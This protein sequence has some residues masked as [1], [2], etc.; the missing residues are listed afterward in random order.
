MSRWFSV[1]GA[2]VSAT[3]LTASGRPAD[4][5]M[6]PGTGTIAGKVTLTLARSAPLPTSAY[7]RRDVA[8]KA[9]QAVPPMRS[10]VVYLSGA[11]P[12]APPAPMVARIVQRGEQ[13]HPPVTVI[14]AGSTVEFPNEDP[15]FHNVFSL[16]R[17]ASFDLGRYRSGES[18]SRRFSKPGIVKVFCDIHSHM[19]AL[20]V[21]LDHPWFTIPSDDGAFAIP[22]VPAGE[23]RI[24]AW[25]ERIG[26]RR[27][28]I[29][30]TAGNS[31]SV[32]FT[33]PVLE[34]TK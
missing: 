26:E 6:Q 21:V 2:V 28:S 10:V 3:M 15:F 19:N 20:I 16:S 23:H 33:L 24:V 17:A 4:A 5:S 22:D 34:K 18:R 14:T 29:R 31:S 32:A 11:R 7:G 13:F 25:H 9:P 27:E 8:P 12:A 1:L 30:V